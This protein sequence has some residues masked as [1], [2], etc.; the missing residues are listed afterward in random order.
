MLGL[1]ILTIYLTHLFEKIIL[2]E[3]YILLFVV[4][5]FSQKKWTNFSCVDIYIE[6]HISEH[7]D[8]INNKV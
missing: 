4:I 7:T 5:N 6:C 1:Q 8:V 3:Y 2:N